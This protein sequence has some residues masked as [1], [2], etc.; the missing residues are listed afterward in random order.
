M[1]NWFS[2]RVP[3]THNGE[4][5]DSSINDVG[6]IGYPMKKD[7]IGPLSHT[8]YRS[9]QKWIKDLYVRLETIKLLEENIGKNFLTLVL[10]VVYWLWQ[11]K[12]QARK[13]KTDKWDCTK[14]ESFCTAKET[15]K[16]VK[17]QPTEWEKIFANNV[18]DKG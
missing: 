16:I 2:T 5:T 6:K 11:Q 3:R 7:E 15:I 4:R 13:A 1:V 14:L 10:T 12:A 17:W 8:T 18:S 9:Q